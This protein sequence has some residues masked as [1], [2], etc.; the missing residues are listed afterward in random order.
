M[1]ISVPHLIVI[2]LVFNI[3]FNLISLRAL[4]SQNILPG[5]VV[6]IKPTGKGSHTAPG[7]NVA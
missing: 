7:T 2:T 6:S 3:F 1:Q 4:L 5:F